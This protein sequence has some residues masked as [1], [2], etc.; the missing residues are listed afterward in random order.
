MKRQRGMVIGAS[1]FIGRHLVQHLAVKGW[2]VDAVTRHA[3][4]GNAGRNSLSYGNGSVEWIEIAHTSDGVTRIVRD[5]GPE[6]IF[7]LAASGVGTE[8]TYRELVAGNEGIVAQIVDGVN[9][10]ATSM[11][12]HAGSWSQY[13]NEVGTRAIVEDNPQVPTCAYGA[14]KVGAELLGRTAA[15]SIGVAFTTLRLFNI[16]G[17]GEGSSRL[18]PYIT[19]MVTAGKQAELTAG[20]QI[21]DFV[22]VDDA[23]RAFEYCSRLAGS[24]SQSFNVATGIGTSVRK[25]A[26]MTADAAGAE[27]DLLVFGARPGRSS[28]A[29]SV[30]GSYSA[31]SIAVGWQPQIAVN[32][33]VQGTVSSILEGRYGES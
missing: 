11:I 17:P 13:G 6:Y 3:D 14:A 28:E 9:A 31:L 10:T 26:V 1:G 15:N 24:G 8:T 16:Y 20:H 33:G 7:N 23:V 12:I 25:M 18:I 27:P 32:D 19:S 2:Q 4:S 22:H 5:R 30:V 21:R 29:A